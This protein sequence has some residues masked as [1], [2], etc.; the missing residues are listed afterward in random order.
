MHFHQSLCSFLP[1]FSHI[2]GHTSI[3][4][5]QAHT[6][7]KKTSMRKQQT[8]STVK[9]RALFT[10]P[11]S[12]TPSAP[13]LASSLYSVGMNSHVLYPLP[14]IPNTPPPCTDSPP[15]TPSAHIMT[16][17]LSVVLMNCAEMLSTSCSPSSPF[18]LFFFILVFCERHY[19]FSWKL[20]S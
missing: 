4:K 13:T 6:G 12:L 15:P 14:P 18:E 2:R 20:K 1:S 19:N 16:F 5:S 9:K 8:N 3:N 17:L 10:I 11:P 7:K